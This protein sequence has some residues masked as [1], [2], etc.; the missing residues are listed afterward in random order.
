M[1]IKNI[2]IINRIN[3]LGAVADL[4]LPVRLT[5]A[6]RKN[7]RKLE[8]EYNDYFESLTAL[9]EKYQDDKESPEYT[10]ELNDLLNIEVDIDFHMVPETMLEVVEFDITLQQLAALDFMI[11]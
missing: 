11:E 10:K 3:G 2:E 1:K 9:K 4:P 7:A 6:I 8:M 5:Y